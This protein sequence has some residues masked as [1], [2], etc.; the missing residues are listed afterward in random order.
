MTPAFYATVTGGQYDTNWLYDAS[1][2][3]IKNIT[4]GYD[5]PL[6]SDKVI[7]RLRVYASCDNVFIFDSYEAGFSPEAATQD[8]ASSDWG[9]YPL[10]RTFSFGVNI[11][12]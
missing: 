8:N 6:K 5:I 7:S 10:S 1:Y 9:A 4:L 12:V 2:L 11:T 3:R